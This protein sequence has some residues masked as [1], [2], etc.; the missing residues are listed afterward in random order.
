MANENVIEC[1]VSLAIVEA[2]NQTLRDV[3]SD[4]N[5][6]LWDVVALLDSMSKAITEGVEF[7]LGFISRTVRM[8]CNKVRAVQ[9]QFDP[10]I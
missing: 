8:A 7:E 10:F 6:E 3:V 1:G 5:D 4:Q 9:D 2:G